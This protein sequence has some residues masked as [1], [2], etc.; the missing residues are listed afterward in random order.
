VVVKGGARNAGR[1]WVAQDFRRDRPVDEY[2]RA[3]GFRCHAA[4][5][6]HQSLQPHL[7]A[8][9]Y[10]AQQRDL[11]RGHRHHQRK[12]H[13]CREERNDL[14]SR[15]PG[16]GHVRDHV[17]RRPEGSGR[18]RPPDARG[19]R[20]RHQHRQPFHDGGAACLRRRRAHCDPVSLLARHELATSPTWALP[21]CATLHSSADPGR[22]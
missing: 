22:R 13:G 16:D 6:R 21:W 17:F 20:H 10:R 1:T 5:W 3:A 9:F 14:R 11:P 7:H 18:F 19:H 12:R 2:G 8:Q 15:L 4:G